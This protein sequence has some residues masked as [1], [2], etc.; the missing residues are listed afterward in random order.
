MTLPC[1][2][3]ALA[4]AAR[5][6]LVV[7][8]FPMLGGTCACGGTDR[9]T[10]KPCAAGKHPITPNG[11]TDASRDPAVIEAWWA[12]APCDLN[13]GIVT[14]AASGIFVLDVD[15][16]NGGREAVAALAKQYG[17]LEVGLD[18]ETGSGGSHY[19]FRH[20]GGMVRNSASKIG[21][22]L[23]IRGDGGYIVAPPSNHKSGGAYRWQH[24][25]A[26]F[27]APAWLI[28]LVRSEPTPEHLDSGPSGEPASSALLEH[29]RK[30]LERHGPAV[31]GQGGDQKTF[32]AASILVNDYDLS[33]ADAAPLLV[34][35]NTTCQPPWD[36]GELL[37]KLRNAKNHANGPRGAARQEFDFARAVDALDAPSAAPV[38]GA[39]DDPLARARELVREALGRKTKKTRLQFMT[40]KELLARDFPPTPWL[41]TG[42]LTDRAVG[43]VAGEPKTT[44][45]WCGME[46]ALAIANGIAAFGEF[47]VP[48][49]RT[50]ALFLV[51][52]DER[53]ARNRLR[54][55]AAGHGMVPAA[56]VERIHLTC[57][58][59]RDLGED[60]DL[61]E[62]VAACL[63]IPDLGCLIL[64]PFRDLHTA[65]ENDSKV[66]SVIMR[67]LR[68]L[69]DI[70]GCTVLF[71]HHS[72]KSGVGTNGRRQGQKMRGSGAIHGAVDGG[73]YLYDL[74]TDGQKFWTNKINVEVKAAR[75][76]G[77]FTLRLDVRDDANGEA[78][79]AAWKR[80]ESVAPVAMSDKQ[81]GA[82]DKVIKALRVAHAK[83][84]PHPPKG[85]G[86][87]K[88]AE[89][90]KKRDDE[91]KYVLRGL[92]ASGHA[93]QLDPA[94]PRN[95][96][97]G[98]VYVM[99]PEDDGAV[100]EG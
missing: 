93:R 27:D 8:L 42:L 9:R 65:D 83:H 89:L 20:P 2:R 98:W 52:D 84:Y 26:A 62:I 91:V 17:D 81:L 57:R 3:A 14:G 49:A 37:T 50:V 87:A 54:A 15:P 31:Q 59:T 34:A 80:E 7:P 23:D 60:E 64:D 90:T 32:V 56:A 100:D 58:H 40:G 21:P 78:E 66:M 35:W 77:N 36:P 55:L 12:G 75:G 24:E 85:L 4:Y 63:D 25:V 44:K 86:I 68:A 11:L 88:L 71:V 69:R 97:G 19:I 22:G 94:N 16:K 38:E 95:P 43:A 33:E 29:A 92:E 61:A 73:I 72:I 82:R 5:G 76:A 79:H 6:W 13:V 41:V 30:R 48:K 18:A 47:G 28:E 45:T 99:Q 96:K 39:P 10:G 46:I 74:D 1:L 51:E 53:S 70:L 67:R